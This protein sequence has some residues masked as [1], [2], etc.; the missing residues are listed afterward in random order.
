[1]GRKNLLILL[2]PLLAGCTTVFTNLTPKQQSR[3]PDNQYMVEVAVNSRQQTMRWESIRPQIMVGREYY[4]MRP[5]LL[6]TNRWEGFVPVAPGT[7]L[8][9]YRYKF[10]FDYNAFGSARADSALSPEYTLRIIETNA[11]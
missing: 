9:H 3:N 1:M 4:P 8:V 2:L 10:D 6:M 11:P 5:T 7:N